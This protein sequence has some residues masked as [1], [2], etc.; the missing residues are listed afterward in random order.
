MDSD[1]HANRL[2]HRL[3]S[4]Q[5]AEGWTLEHVAALRGGAGASEAAPGARRSATAAAVA[6]WRK[7][8]T[9][10][11]LDGADV[12]QLEALVLG[13]GLRPAFDIEDD[14]YGVLP[15]PWQGLNERREAL[16]PL[17][18]GIG[19]IDVT[20]HPDTD[21]A[22]LGTAFVCG[23]ALLITNRHVAAEFVEGTG[24]GS[25]IRFIPGRLASVDLKQEVGSLASLP[26]VI[27]APVLVL[28]AWDVALLQVEALPAGVEALPLAGSVPPAI[29]GREAAVVGFPALDREEDVIAQ[30]EIFRNV[31]DRK[32]LQPGRIKGLGPVQSPRGSVVALIHD[33]STLGGN[34]GSAVI[35]V[36]T[37]SVWGLH[38]SGKT[39]VA[40]FAV[41][42]WELVA[43]R[44]VI[45]A[46]VQFNA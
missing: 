10:V 24:E 9:G 14:A 8:D 27:T 22:K 34:S 32:R 11:A 17:I 18:R 29:G 38:F 45:A 12:F 7:L 39:H 13:Q 2:L 30:M 46:G 4:L 40:N 25:E 6:A 28:D 15:E 42:I 3:K 44:R 43:D 20:G 19:R 5:M 31:F 1:N 16:R 23:R 33:C 26:L 37:A 35:D 36:E 21:P 41:P